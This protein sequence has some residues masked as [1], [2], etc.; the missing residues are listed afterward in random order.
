VAF[1]GLP[2]YT[3]AGAA[4]MGTFITS[5]AGVSFYQAISPFN[6]DLTVAPD[7]PLGVLFGVGG[8][9]GMY[10]GARLQKHLP[11]RLI[12]WMLVAVIL[13]VAGKYLAGVFALR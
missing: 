11:A 1:L 2:V 3:V 10:C 12:K 5:V 9:A 8:A 7:W 6:P 4:L 13:F